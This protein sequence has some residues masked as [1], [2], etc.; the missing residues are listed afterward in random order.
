LSS[1]EKSRVKVEYDPPDHRKNPWLAPTLFREDITGSAHL[2]RLSF[3]LPKIVRDQSLKG[4]CK[5][6]I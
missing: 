1:S 3:L 6:R 5:T 4:A 2:F